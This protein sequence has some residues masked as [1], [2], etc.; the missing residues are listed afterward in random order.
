ML[1]HFCC[2][3]CFDNGSEIPIQLSFYLFVLAVYKRPVLLEVDLKAITLVNFLKL[4]GS[5][6]GGK[7]LG[8][9]FHCLERVSRGN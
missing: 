8:P 5:L 3:A 9:S 7:G 6:P 2:S 4:T 1:N